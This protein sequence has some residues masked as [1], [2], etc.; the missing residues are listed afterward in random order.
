MSN[1]KSIEPILLLSSYIEL[2][3]KKLDIIS[4]RAIAEILKDLKIGSHLTEVIKL[5]KLIL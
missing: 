5:A 2:P 3:C 4:V 1:K